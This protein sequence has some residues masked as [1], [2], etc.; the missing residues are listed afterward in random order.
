MLSLVLCYGRKRHVDGLIVDFFNMDEKECQVT[1]FYC[2]DAAVL[3]HVLLED[4]GQLED[5]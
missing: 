5:A 2:M 3:A 1:S 4:F